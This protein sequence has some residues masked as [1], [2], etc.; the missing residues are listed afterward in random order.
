MT[1]NAENALGHHHLVFYNISVCKMPV[2]YPT[3]PRTWAQHAELRASE[4]AQY[5]DSLSDEEYAALE[6]EG[7]LSDE[8][9]A[10]DGAEGCACVDEGIDFFVG[11]EVSKDVG[12]DSDAQ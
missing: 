4:Y 1:P 10:G 5:L 12:A 9:D 2:K 3:V 11:G 7:K 6:A 8:E